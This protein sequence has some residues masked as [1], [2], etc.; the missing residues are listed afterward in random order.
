MSIFSD[1]NVLRFVTS[2]TG[3]D[4]AGKIPVLNAAGQLDLSFW[5]GGGNVIEVSDEGS[6]IGDDFTNLNFVGGGVTATD[7]G[8]GVANISIPVGATDL[9]GAYTGG[10]TI[11][12]AGGTGDVI[13]AG[14]EA[15]Q[16]T[17]TNGLDVDTIIDFDGTNFDFLATTSSTVA[18][19]G[20]GVDLNLNSVAGSVLIEGGEAVT[21][22]VE[23]LGTSGGVHIESQGFAAANAIGIDSAGGIDIN[24]SGTQGITI[25]SSG[26]LSIDVA[27]TSSL[28]AQSNWFHVGNVALASSGISIFADNTNGGLLS[29]SFVNINAVNTGGQIASISIGS[30]AGVGARTDRI[31]FFGAVG[32]GPA[33][34]GTTVT[35]SRGGNAALTSLLTVLTGYGLIVNSTVA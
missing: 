28:N 17:A 16:I 18:V 23:L 22:T 26:P 34:G 15:L 30:N 32:V 11:T 19:T 24:A 3:A 2:S 1:L 13:I 7:G 35:G 6:S 29:N 33:S 31:G 27:A 12:T 21:N 14:T 5:A 4:D 10:N 8:G 9:Q 20:A 25:D